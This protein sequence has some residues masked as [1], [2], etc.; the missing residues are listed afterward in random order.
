MS[1]ASVERP[2]EDV[3]GDLLGGPVPGNR[4]GTSIGSR[5]DTYAT[6]S[7]GGV[8][9]ATIVLNHRIRIEQ[10]RPSTSSIMK[11]VY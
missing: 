2:P 6:T 9:L 5:Y 8:I 11:P 10:T 4:S 3:G 7:L 1:G